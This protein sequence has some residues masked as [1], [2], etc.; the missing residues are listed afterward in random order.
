MK[1]IFWGLAVLFFGWLFTFIG[2]KIMTSSYVGDRP[3]FAIAL[4]IIFVGGVIA[5][6]LS[7]LIEE[8]MIK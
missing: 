4:A 8:I 6:G 2:S 5:V 7:K 1:H 3:L